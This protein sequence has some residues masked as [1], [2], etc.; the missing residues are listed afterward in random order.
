M[1]FDLNLTELYISFFTL[2]LYLVTSKEFWDQVDEDKIL[3][4]GED[5]AYKH[6]FELFGYSIKEYLTSIGKFDVKI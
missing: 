1:L 2:T 6:D 3:E 4:L 5:Y